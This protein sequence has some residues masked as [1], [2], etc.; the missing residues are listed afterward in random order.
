MTRRDIS[1]TEQSSG[2]PR[3]YSVAQVADI[4]GM[5]TVTVY[6]AIRA[7]ELSAL[8]IRGRVIVPA[9]VIDSLTATAVDASAAAGGAA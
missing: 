1:R 2:A 7:G 4:L 5:S 9:A 6:R 3:F 8:R